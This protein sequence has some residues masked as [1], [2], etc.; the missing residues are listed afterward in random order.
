LIP[1]PQTPRKPSPRSR[2]LSGISSLTAFARIEPAEPHA[3]RGSPFQ[4]TRIGIPRRASL[5]SAS[6]RVCSTTP[7]QVRAGVARGPDGHASEKRE[8]ATCVTAGIARCQFRTPGG[9]KGRGALPISEPALS[10]RSEDIRLRNRERAEG[11]RGR[12][13]RDFTHSRGR[14]E[15]VRGGCRRGYP[16]LLLKGPRAFDAVSVATSV[17]QPVPRVHVRF[18]DSRPSCSP[19]METNI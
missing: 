1:Q 8:P 16:R 11:F 19:Q 15:G 13:G 10:E 3:R 18:A 2:T 4:S 9:L 17:I 12:C 6:T 14:A 7:P 5:R